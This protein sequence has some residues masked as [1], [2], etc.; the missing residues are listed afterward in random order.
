M[1]VEEGKGVEKN[2]S[3]ERGKVVKR[4]CGKRTVYRKERW[5]NRTV[6]ERTVKGKQVGKDIGRREKVGKDG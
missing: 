2:S 4:R 5:K 1:T 6:W 3:A